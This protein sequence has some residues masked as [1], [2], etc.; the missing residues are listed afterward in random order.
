MGWGQRGAK[1]WGQ[2]GANPWPERHGRDGRE[3]EASKCVF[4]STR[5]SS[6]PLGQSPK[7]KMVK[8]DLQEEA[9][10]L[11]QDTFTK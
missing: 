8:T 2:G 1:G 10:S 3:M 11:Y 5:L 9:L 6:E 7:A 4:S